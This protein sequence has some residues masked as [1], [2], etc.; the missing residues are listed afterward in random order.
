[1]ANFSTAIDK[2]LDDEGGYSRTP[3]DA[4]LSTNFGICQ[5]DNPTLDIAN[6]TRDDAIAY[7]FSNWWTRYNFSQVASDDLA[8][9]WFNHAVNCGIEPITKAVQS[10]LQDRLQQAGVFGGITVD[11]M[12]GPATI[13]C[14][15]QNWAPALMP[16]LQEKLWCHYLLI[17]QAHP[18]DEKFRQGWWNRVYNTTMYT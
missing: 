8:S 10:T 18:E 6:L 7:Y 4:G 16:K 12:I 15:N 2:L 9:Y 1:M 17:L 3:G 13:A 14:A 5:R 11:G